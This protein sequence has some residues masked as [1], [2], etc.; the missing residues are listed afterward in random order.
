[1]FKILESC[2]PTEAKDTSLLTSS[3]SMGMWPANWCRTKDSDDKVR[4]GFS[5]LR[6]YM[7]RWTK[8]RAIRKILATWRNDS[9]MKVMGS[10][11]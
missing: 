1:M 5:L 6:D 7:S 2:H 9:A 11:S 8:K 4:S 3:L 10:K